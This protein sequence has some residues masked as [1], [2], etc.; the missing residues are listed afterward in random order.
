MYARS[1]EW[2]CE[3]KNIVGNKIKAAGNGRDRKTEAKALAMT[4]LLS[5]LLLFLIFWHKGLFPVGNGSVVMSDLYSQYVPLLYHFYDVIT[6]QAGMFWESGISG[7]CNIYIDTINEVLNP[8]NYLLFLFGR[9]QIYL[10]VNVIMALYLIAAALSMHVFLLQAFPGK[11]EWNVGISMAYAFG[12][13][14][15][16]NFQIIKW[17]YFPVLFPLFMLALMRLYRGKGR[18][19]ALLLA[20]QLMLSVQFGFMLLLFVL[21]GS[22]AFLFLTKEKEERKILAGRLAFYTAAGLLLSAVVLLPGILLLFTSSRAEANTSYFSVMGKHGLDDLF[23]RLFQVFHPV[24]AAAILLLLKSFVKIPQKAAF[25]KEKRK[26][27]TAA[28]VVFAAGLLFG[29]VWQP[30]NL[31][32]HLGSY[33]C[34]PVRY[35]YMVTFVLLVL[36]KKFLE[37][38]YIKTEES[39]G[40]RRWGWFPEV[41]TTVCLAGALGLTLGFEDRITNAF[42][43]LSISRSCPAE[44]ILVA[45]ILLLC[46]VAALAGFSCR[47]RKWCLGGVLFV[48]GLCTQLFFILPP[49]NSVRLYNEERYQVMTELAHSQEESAASGKEET[50]RL[51]DFD[52]VPLNQALVTGIPSLSG[53]LPT[54]DKTF[55]QAMGELGYSVPWVATETL[56]GTVFS[57]ELLGVGS[58]LLEAEESGN[59]QGEIFLQAQ[60]QES[61]LQGKFT[62]FSQK[63]TYPS[64]LLLPGDIRTYQWNPEKTVFE[65]QQDWYEAMGGEGDLFEIF[66]LTEELPDFEEEGILYLDPGILAQQVKA[67]RYGEEMNF[68]VPAADTNSHRILNLGVW[69]QNAEDTEDTEEKQLV[70]QNTDGVSLAESGNALLACV[71]LEKAAKAKQTVKEAR[72]DMQVGKH[73]ISGTVEGEGVLFLPAASIAGW[74]AEADGREVEISELFGGF[75]GIALPEGVHQV[76]FSFQPPGFLLGVAFTAV[77]ALLWLLG[78]FYEKTEKKQIGTQILYSLYVLIAAA[79]ILLVYVLPIILFPAAMVVKLAAR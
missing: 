38:R 12:G 53:Y 26:S 57:D 45:V 52:K 54:G 4:G 5:V 8:F 20:Y 73:E 77:G 34:F 70:I 15:A 62:L 64:A 60:E 9:D 30:I 59:G 71:D 46:L 10:A 68:P 28:A 74:R 32:W 35:G 76:R 16:Y 56:G 69:G 47:N 39:T 23:E 67:Y 21:F 75:L 72:V 24:T 48:Y 2:D 22:A 50:G 17:M 63:G 66:P 31:L 37:N 27:L 1:K 18:A 36:V 78:G 40:K 19:Y 58:S 55:Q 6:G 13:Y 14:M 25:L 3:S 44:T 7:G 11:R 42:S 79:A 43:T 65:N 49:D 61:F 51:Q 41:L 33:V 29:I